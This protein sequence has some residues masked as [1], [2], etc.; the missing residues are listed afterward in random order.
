MITRYGPELCLNG[1]FA[2]DSTAGW[3]LDAGWSVASE[4]LNNLGGVN[5]SRASYTFSTEPGKQY[6]FMFDVISAVG[7]FVAEARRDTRIGSVLAFSPALTAGAN[8]SILFTAATTTS[9][10]DF[11]DFGTSAAFDNVSVMN[12]YYVAAYQYTRRKNKVFRPF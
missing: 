5:G 9:V 11:N 2:G 3:T 10:I 6:R 8:Q 7:T 1:T 12:L 4:R